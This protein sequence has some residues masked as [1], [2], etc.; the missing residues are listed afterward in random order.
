MVDVAH[1]G[2]ERHALVAHAGKVHLTGRLVERVGG[3]KRQAHDLLGEDAQDGGVHP[4]RPL[5]HARAAPDGQR[6][7]LGVALLELAHEAL[8]PAR[9]ELLDEPHHG[10]QVALLARQLLEHVGNA[11][12]E[13]VGG[14]HVPEGLHGVLDRAE[15]LGHG[16]D[17]LLV[18]TAGHRVAPD[19]GE[20]VVAHRVTGARARSAA[21]EVGEVDALDVVAV[22]CEDGT[23]LAVELPLGVEHQEARPHLQ[24]VGLEDVSRL[25]RAG[26][27]E[28][29]QVV[30]EPRGARVT[31]ELAAL[32]EDR[33]GSGGGD[34][35]VKG[36]IE[37]GHL[38]PPSW[39]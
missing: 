7:A 37:R 12:R 26:G 28:H 34:G 29:E 8:G 1:R 15:G 32:G 5:R 33:G 4:L 35:G 38:S 31:G 9:L 23:H 21:C 24:E 2:K 11:A 16:E 30:V 25:A 6:V 18:G 14:R 10:A 3:V 19:V 17:V 13:V 27:A 39:T 20:G 22:A 36:G